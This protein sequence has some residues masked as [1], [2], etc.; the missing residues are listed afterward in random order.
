MDASAAMFVASTLAPDHAFLPHAAHVEVLQDRHSELRVDSS[1]SPPPFGL[2]SKQ[3]DCRV[4]RSD[5]WTLCR[6]LH[7]SVLLE[8]QHSPREEY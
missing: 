8:L 5:G 6:L 4:T 2:I 1:G 7:A 3:D